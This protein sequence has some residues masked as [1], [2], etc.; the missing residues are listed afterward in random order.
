MAN[1]KLTILH[2]VRGRCNPD[3]ANGVD[4]T[5][6]Y[7][8]RE[9]ARQG[10]QVHL[11]SQTT[12]DVIE[13]PGVTVHRVGLWDNPLGA[14]VE[15]RKIVGRVKPDVAHFHS[16]N[17]PSNVGLGRYLQRQGIGY[18]VTPN[19]NCAR[20]VL[21]R[22][23]WLKIPYKILFERPFMNAALFV[24][25]V[26]DEDEILDYGVKVPLIDA[27]N[28]ID[29]ADLPPPPDHNLILEKY[30]E[31]EGRRLLIF[32]GRLDRQQ[33]GLD[34]LL[35]A[36]VELGPDRESLGILL[37]GPDWKGSKAI[38]EAQIADGGLGAGVKFYGPAFGDEKYDL[39]RSAECFLHPSR[40]EGMP[41]AVIEAMA[42]GQFCFVSNRADPGGW[43]ERENA[44][45]VIESE[46]DGAL[47]GGLQRICAMGDD[48]VEEFKMR[49][50][51]VLKEHFGWSGIS[52]K[53]C[54]GYRQHL[55]KD[56]AEAES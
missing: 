17:I 20:R 10:H 34:R 45:L 13:V 49:S 28:G 1:G 50:M 54:A 18:V 40:W 33:K 4:K 39:I 11:L 27:P 56:G 25:S 35:D 14:P 38:L 5:I 26:G 8:C 43:L 29:T 23:P 6:Y 30:P 15:V 42:A 37:V 16:M 55:G 32:V 31:W 47:L 12:K 46:D 2:S 48:E 3:S 41:F 36:L 24:H 19:G 21:S 9:Q 44:A 51:Q 53:I 7:L 22:R 52:A